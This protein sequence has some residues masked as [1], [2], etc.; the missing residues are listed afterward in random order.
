MTFRKF[1]CLL[2]VALLLGGC[3]P[4]GNTPPASTPATT[5]PVQ[6]DTPQ[7]DEDAL[8]EQLFSPENRISLSLQMTGTELAKLQQDYTDYSARGSKSPIYRMADL[9]ITIGDTVHRIHQVG[10]RM[11]GNTSRTDFYSPD[12]GIHSLIHLKI[13]FQE[14]FDDEAYYGADA[15]QWTE[16]ARKERKNRTFATL[17]KLD[18]KWNKCDDSTYIKEHYAYEMYRSFGVLAPRTNLCSVDWAGLHTGV[19]TIYEPIDKIFLEKRL[20]E[21]QLGGDLYKLGWTYEGAKFTNLNSVGIEDEDKGEFFCYDLKTNKKT[22][23]HAALT[24]LITTLQQGNV[25]RADFSSLVDT[26]N[27]LRYAAVSYLLG[28]PDDLRNNYN[29]C[30]IYFRADTGQMLVI[31]YDYDRCLGITKEWAPTPDGVTGDDPF[32]LTLASGNGQQENPLF[33]YSVCAGGYFVREY[34]AL[35]SEMAGSRWMDNFHFLQAVTKAQGHYQTLTRPSKSFRNARDHSFT[36]DPEKAS[37]YSDRGNVN[38]ADYARLKKATLAKALEK[39]DDYA[40]GNPAV[41]ADLTIRADATNW[42]ILPQW[43]L[44]AAGDGL[45]QFSLH[46]GGQIRFKI[47]SRVLDRWYGSECLSE[48]TTVP[49]D[50]DS[51]T[52]IL[53]E[54][55]D[56]LV[57]FDPESETV[58]II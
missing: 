27:F 33:L 49:W 8:Y 28:N 35:L 16:Q 53:L 54:K 11:K 13:S 43:A 3:T 10:V 56:Y 9:E 18:M 39:L 57:R 1:I 24:N 37:D 47:Y 50:T 12:E 29:N 26:D 2:L 52:N 30:Y 34:A 36:F 15:L 23:T 5:L 14:T 6:Q 45:W 51:H 31:P 32:T 20:P 44:T 41:P 19:Y 4:A 42:E 7:N 55:G 46:T 25:T 21:S 40:A 22:S 17:E 38:F 58:T 48:N